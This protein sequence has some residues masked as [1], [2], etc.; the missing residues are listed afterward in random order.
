MKLSIARN[1]RLTLNKAVALT[2]LVQ[3]NQNDIKKIT[4]S[5]RITQQKTQM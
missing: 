1:S 5:M 4:I 3:R 2:I